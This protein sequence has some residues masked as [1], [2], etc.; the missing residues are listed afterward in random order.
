MIILLQLI[1]KDLNN[2]LKLKEIITFYNLH[3]KFNNEIIPNSKT[4]CRKRRI[5]YL[6]VNI[7]DYV[8]KSTKRFNHLKDLQKYTFKNKCFYPL[9]KAKGDYKLK[10]MLR[11]L[12]GFKKNKKNRQ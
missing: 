3:T 1:G 7:Y 2:V 9:N 10:I 12:I 5:K 6:Y 4:Q 11:S 8:G